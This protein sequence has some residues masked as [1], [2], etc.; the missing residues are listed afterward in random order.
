M[1][2]ESVEQRLVDVDAGNADAVNGV[3]GSGVKGDAEA[4]A[5]AKADAIGQVPED[6]DP[7][8]AEAQDD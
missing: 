3:D 7:V 8:A 5:E 1:G 4:D 2:T 6:P